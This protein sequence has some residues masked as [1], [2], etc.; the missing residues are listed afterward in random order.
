MG[1][2]ALA[3]GRCTGGLRT[4]STPCFSLASLPG[5]CEQTNTRNRNRDSNQR[6]ERVTG[7]HA[8]PLDFTG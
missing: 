5:T 6:E 8:V 7:G 4:E 3:V 1:E 2:E